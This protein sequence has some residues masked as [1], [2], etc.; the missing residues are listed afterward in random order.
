MKKVS[1]FLVLLICF[2][3]A[4]FAASSA[5]AA[6]RKTAV[7]C[8]KLAENYLSSRDF[9]NAMVQ[10]ELGLSYDDTVSDLWYIKAA[11][12]SGLGA[13]RAEVLP[14]AVKA[15]T[16]GEWVDYNRDGARILYADLLCDTGEGAQAVAV[17]DANP[18][19]YSSDAE[20]IRTKAYYRMLT[21]ESIEKARSKVNAARKIYPADMRFPRLFF[22]YE[23]M[24]SSR[25][26]FSEI[27]SGTN[28]TSAALVQKI[29]D[30]F[31]AKMPEY[32]NP[33]AELEIYAALFASG[34]KQLRM[35]KA[36]SAHGMEHP[37]YAVAALK[38]G[39]MTQQES[40]DYFCS[41]A[42]TSVR[43]DLL[44]SILPLITDEITVQS[45]REHLEAYEGELL[46][47]TNSD[48]ETELSV[49]YM[50]GRPHTFCWDETS[51]GIVEWAGTCDFGVP[52]VISLTDGNLDVFYGTY[53]AVVKVVSKSQ[54]NEGRN[55]QFTIPDEVFRWSPCEIKRL[56]SVHSLTGLDFFVV[57]PVVP[58]SRFDETA[59]VSACSSY[60]MPGTER[61]GSLIRFS[62]LD[63][64]VQSADYYDGDTLYARCEF[65]NG[66]PRVRTVDNDGDGIF[67]T[68]ETLGFDPENT[69]NTPEEEQNQVMANT[70]G[71][72]FAGS[73]LY[74]K[75]IQIDRDGDTVPDFS[76]EYLADGGKITAWDFDGD[77]NWDV[78]YKK[79]P[80][81]SQEEPLV[82]DSQ[83]YLEPEHSLVTVT[84]WNGEPV[85]VSYG[86]E[87]YSV[88][89][90]A[91]NSFYWVG[92][93]GNADDEYYVTE[94][95]DMFARQG[96]SVV[97]ESNSCRMIA[98]RIGENL[99]V[100]ILPEINTEEYEADGLTEN[101]FAE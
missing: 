50:R 92:T 100:H 91:G 55:L 83:F 63:G 49:K 5:G 48:G 74:V 17:L 20:F 23:Y 26:E 101:E 6:N 13:P 42:D 43:L 87:E 71:L 73:G 95:F 97:L 68:T 79:Y 81:K 84:L 22:T 89:Q 46:V 66:F 41:F 65:E 35:L 21:P 67:E 85:K 37:L 9:E 27:A 54:K 86:E 25:A 78:R 14:L 75:M 96:I 28:E 99:Y 18:F 44:E 98:V 8:L 88:T 51:D 10:A 4:V 24:L 77:G 59:L 11:A 39:L 31:I 94:H 15:L 53:P 1:V 16:E 93:A 82:E 60:E 38:T 56:E 52:E 61:P 30:T 29:A 34:E 64:A 57:S 32:D 36:F 45:V 76:E 90:G 70:F 33:D 7:R 40:W 12:K 58:N 80:R 3:L 62:V 2:P 47:D 19:I 69:M 72:P